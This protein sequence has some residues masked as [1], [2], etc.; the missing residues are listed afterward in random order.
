[1][2]SQP[3]VV[4]FSVPPWVAAF[5]GRHAVLASQEEAMRLV[6]AASRR[7]VAEGTG[8]PFAAAIVERDSGRLVALG[9]NLVTQ[10]NL[11]ILH[12]EMVAITLAQRKLGV[13]DL[14]GEGMPAHALIT[15]TE[16]CAMCLGAIPWSGIRQVVIG[17]TEADARR[18][19]FD[20]GEKPRDWPEALV[21][22]GIA[23]VGGVLR[24]EAALVLEEYRRRGGLLYNGRG[25]C[26]PSGER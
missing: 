3:A 20:E 13:F 26:S 16:P 17:A 22:R 12:A 23:V 14:G 7:N 6:I 25:C 2:F 11:S 19:G 9:V 15:T 8:G 5:A 21:R 4:A 10:E 1:M 24:S 18:I